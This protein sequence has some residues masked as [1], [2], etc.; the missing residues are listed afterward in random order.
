MATVLGDGDADTDKCGWGVDG[1]TNDDDG[2]D[3]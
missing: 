2:R 3:N 1:D